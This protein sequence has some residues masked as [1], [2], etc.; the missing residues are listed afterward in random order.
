MNGRK[1][2]LYRKMVPI[3]VET[4]YKN[5]EYVR[6]QG[7]NVPWLWTFISTKEKAYINYGTPSSPKF[8]QITKNIRLDEK[9]TRAH[10]KL[11]KRID[12]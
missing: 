4:T 10:V 11:L 6:R 3:N 8:V 7:F 2:K 9:C 5:V 12:S 1:S